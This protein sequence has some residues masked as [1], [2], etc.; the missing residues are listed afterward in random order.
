MLELIIYPKSNDPR[1]VSFSPFCAKSEVFLKLCQVE[2]TIKEFNDNP[3]KFP[4]GKLPVIQH[5]GTII[6]DSSCIQTYVEKTFNVDL[7]S[8]LGKEQAAVGYMVSKVC[9]DHLYWCILHERWF[10]DKN[11][12]TLKNQYFGHIPSI[13]R[14]FLTGM[15]RKAQKKSALGHGMSRHSGEQVL[16]FGREAIGRIAD[17]LGDKPFIGGD[18]VSSFDAS[19]YGS[20][21]SM[22]HCDLGPELQ[23]ETKSHKNLVAYDERMFQLVYGS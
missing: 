5:N 7:D 23:S 15:I 22:I 18:K 4:N 16:A 11:W 19:L 21:S 9:E 8:H 17:L 3:A 1:L 13:M 10:I 14:G 12:E 2:F 6:A 20:I